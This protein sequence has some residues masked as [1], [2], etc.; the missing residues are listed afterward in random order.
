MVLHLRLL[1]LLSVRA[2]VVV[3]VLPQLRLTRPLQTFCLA[4]L[5]H[6]LHP[7]VARNVAR[8]EEQRINHIRVLNG[9]PH[10]LVVCDVPA[11]VA[12]SLVE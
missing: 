12:V 11:A 9:K 5:V 7:P 8:A 3:V 2:P 10:P 4:L 6:H 1:M